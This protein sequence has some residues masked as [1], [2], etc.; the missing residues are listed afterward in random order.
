MCG[1]TV[2]VRFPAIVQPVESR[3]IKER[4]RPFTVFAEGSGIAIEFK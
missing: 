2:A 4:D 3:E 1:L